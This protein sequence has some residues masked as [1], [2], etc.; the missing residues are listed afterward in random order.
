MYKKL[1]V[2][3]ILIISLIVISELIAFRI[4]SNIDEAETKQFRS[5][6]VLRDIEHIDTHMGSLQRL[7][8]DFL[9]IKRRTANLKENFWKQLDHTM[10]DI[11]HE[12]A[13]LHNGDCKTCHKMFLKLDSELKNL[14]TNLR[15]SDRSSKSSTDSKINQTIDQNVINLEH[16]ADKIDDL[17]LK[18]LVNATKDSKILSSELNMVRN[19]ERETNKRL[20]IKERERKAEKHEGLKK[21]VIRARGLT[22]KTKLIKYHISNLKEGIRKSDPAKTQVALSNLFKLVKFKPIPPPLQ[23]EC[24]SCHYSLAKDLP[25]KAKSVTNM[26]NKL[27]SINH[28]GIAYNLAV[29]DLDESIGRFEKSVEKILGLARAHENKSMQAAR[30]AR[31]SLKMFLLMFGIIQDFKR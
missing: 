24:Y 28:D 5:L 6:R 7:A 27:F 12:V 29:S 9:I 25:K 3:V 4:L 16:A 14:H 31:K 18:E 26:A 13:P 20:S 17:A 23:G 22:Q 10:E 8:F 1:F 15:K 30:D 2:V 21:R 19:A 11:D